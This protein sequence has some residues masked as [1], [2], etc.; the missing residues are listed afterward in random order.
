MS[1]LVFGYTG[2]VAPEAAQKGD[3]PLITL[4]IPSV[5]VKYSTKKSLKSP[6]VKVPS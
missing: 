6:E 4:R 1:F 3:V 5:P 2:E